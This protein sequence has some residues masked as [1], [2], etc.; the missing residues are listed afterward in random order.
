MYVYIY[1]YI[2]IMWSIMH[3]NIDSQIFMNNKYFPLNH[4]TSN[5]RGVM[6]QKTL[7]TTWG[8]K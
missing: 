4:K 2:Y 7:K 3:L 6:I 5:H 1:V 8:Q